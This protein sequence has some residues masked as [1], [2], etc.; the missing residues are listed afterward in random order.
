MTRFYAALLRIYPSWFRD[1][2]GAELI[3]AFAADRANPRHRGPLGGCRFW[4]WI[5][6]GGTY[7]EAKFETDAD[8]IQAYEARIA[9]LSGW[10][11]SRPSSSSS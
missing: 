10:S 11:A 1:R 6:R 9:H 8:L 4:G 7:Q 5:L 2:Y 3:A